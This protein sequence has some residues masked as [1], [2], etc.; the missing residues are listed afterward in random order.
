MYFDTKI[1][2]TVKGIRSMTIVLICSQ[3]VPCSVHPIEQLYMIWSV[4]LSFPGHQQFVEWYKGTIARL[5][6][7]KRNRNDKKLKSIPP[8][9]KKKKMLVGSCSFC[10]SLLEE[11][12]TLKLCFLQFVMGADRRVNISCLRCMASA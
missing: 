9:K 5:A 8:K 6:A 12:T 11:K 2:L 1:Q 4:F 3:L 7:Q 10:T